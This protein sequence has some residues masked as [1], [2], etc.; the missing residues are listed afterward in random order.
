MRNWKKQEVYIAQENKEPSLSFVVEDNEVIAWA[1]YDEYEGT[2]ISLISNWEENYK[3]ILANLPEEELNYIF[4]I[5]DDAPDG[6]K[7]FAI[8]LKEKI[9]KEVKEAKEEP[10][11]YIPN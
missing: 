7:E 4:K 3:E 11:L 8:Q 6:I 2:V 1:L 9:Q 10:R 5:L